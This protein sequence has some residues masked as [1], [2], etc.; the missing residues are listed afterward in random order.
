MSDPLLFGV[1]S[2]LYLLAMVFY[3]FFIILKKELLGKIASISVYIGFVV[4]TMAFFIRWYIFSKAFSLPIANS[5]PITNLY[6]SLIFFAWCLILGNIFIERKFNTKIFGVI[7]TALAGMSIAF[8]DAIG[9][10][11]TV[12]PILPALKSNWLLAHA[13]LSFV[14]Y[15]AFSL[16]FSAAILNLAY[17]IRNKKSIL[18]IYW[19]AALGIFVYT[20]L[21]L[22]VDFI[23]N[24]VN[25]I[26]DG[27]KPFSLLKTVPDEWKI[28][29]LILF[30]CFIVLFYIFGSKLGSMVDR[31][32]IKSELLETVEYKMITIGFMI[33]TIGGLVFGAI[34][35][36][37]SWGRYWAWDPKETWAFI[38]W[39]VYAFYIHMRFIKGRD[40]VSASAI[41]V[42]GFIITI[43][44]YIGVNLLLSGLHSYGGM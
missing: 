15:A 27:Y 3:L 1:A 21:L 13:S 2:I 35:A 4:H 6:E 23:I 24:L 37:I 11:K 8:V 41:A 7:I 26:K 14:A 19:T 10:N 20:T 42:I 43:F 17:N 32:G 40:G 9:A 22:I 16:S 31:F 34:W 33:F 28:L 18:Y 38:T 25:R 44:T 5:I 36:D 29:L 30:I 12:Q 39:L